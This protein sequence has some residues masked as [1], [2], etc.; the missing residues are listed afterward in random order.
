MDHLKVVK[1]LHG[2]CSEGCTINGH[3]E[4]VEWLHQALNS[5]FF[6]DNK[7]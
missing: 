6:K 3:I 4:V 2:N 7:N 5:R 1:W